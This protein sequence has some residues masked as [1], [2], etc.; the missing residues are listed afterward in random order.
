MTPGRTVSSEYMH[1][2]KT[3]SR[4]AYDLV[5]SDMLHYP[6][7]ELPVTLTSLEINGPGGYG[8]QP[9]REMIAQKCNVEPDCVVPSIGTSLANHIAMAVLV[10]PGDEVLLEQPTYGLIL[11]T[12]QYIGAS[13]QRFRRSFDDNFLIDTDQL[14]SHMTRKTKLVVLTNLHNPSSALTDQTTLQ[15]I[16]ELAARAG[17]QVLVD[18]VYLDAVFD[19]RP[20]SAFHAGSNIVTTNSLTKVYGLSGLRCGWILA[21]P[22]LAEKMR[23]LTDLFHSTPTHIGELLSVI[24]LRELVR[25]TSRARLLI[26]ANSTI[27]NEF[28]ASCSRL[29]AHPHRYGLIAFPKLS[30]GNVE[31][32]CSFLREAYDT[33]VA[34]GR[35]FELP[36]HVRI[37]IG[38][39]TAMLRTALQNLKN[40]LDEFRKRG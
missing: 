35:F 30:D 20:R 9:L 8:Y 4:A 29:K 10:Q 13:V 14:K 21:Q 34:P 40:A 27:L 2:V 39:E 36:D 17:A 1:W 24:A 22:A 3:S 28:F 6:L 15:K 32:F 38:M 12:L 18:E 31:S 26:E 5:S 33:G 25:L 19:Q 11:S 16:G 23:R 7:S 37:G